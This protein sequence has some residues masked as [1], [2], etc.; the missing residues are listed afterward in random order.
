MIG[1]PGPATRNELTLTP[2]PGDRTQIKLRITYPS[3]EIR[4][5]VLGTGMVNG[6]EASYARLEQTLS[7][8]AR[9][10]QAQRG[11]GTRSRSA[12]Q[13]GYACSRSRRVAASVR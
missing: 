9:R 7:G 3:R 4:D 6:M 8:R 5:M 10:S 1:I 12:R 13:A 11:M 2:R